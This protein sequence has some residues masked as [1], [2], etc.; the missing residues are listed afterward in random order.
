MKRA[1]DLSIALILLALMIVVRPT[2]AVML[3]FIPMVAKLTNE[4]LSLALRTYLNSF[5]TQWIVVL[6]GVML[7]SISPLLWFWQTG[8]FVVYSYGKET[9][10]FIHP[11]FIQFLFSYEKGWFIWSPYLFIMLLFTMFVFAKRDLMLLI[12]FL[13]PLLLIIYILSS[14]WCWTYG[15]GF[16]QRPLI[17]Y[18]PLVVLVFGTAIH[19]IDRKWR[20][21]IVSMG[22]PFIGLSLFQG[23]QVHEGI[24][25][26]GVTTKHTYWSH[27][28]QWYTDAPKAEIPK[29]YNSVYMSQVGQAEL[30]EKKSYSEALVLPVEGVALIKLTVELSG[31]H[32]DTNVRI[33]LSSKDASY[34]KTEFN[35]M[36]IYNFKRSMSYAFPVGNCHSDT[37]YAYVW[38]GDTKSNVSIQSLKA[39][40]YKKNERD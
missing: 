24:I 35:G 17:E 9:F 38:N 31:T 18:I 23:F 29:N 25:R 32:E 7:L 1:K 21:G 33:V 5:R 10:D 20:I 39:E 12:L 2:N 3:L 14:W 34:Y 16:G 13:W 15:D 30:S 6:S 4:S 36:Y 19:T 22:I 28:F 26:G 11:H 37:L 27:F 8:S 40:A